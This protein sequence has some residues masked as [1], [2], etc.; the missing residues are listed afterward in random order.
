MASAVVWQR[1][2]GA[3]L[4]IVGLVLFDHVNEAMSWWL[5]LLVF[6]AP[7]LSFAGYLLEPKAGAA[8]YNAAHI[9]ALGGVLL[10]VGFAFYLPLL[11]TLGALW[12]AHCGFDRMLGY[13]LKL[14]DG[15]SHTHLG[16]IGKA[17]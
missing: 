1:V 8:I 6:F 15:F 17:K 2:E 9:Y 5:A 10:A 11:S 7:D 16:M 13:G 12:L 4:F 3:L 14:P